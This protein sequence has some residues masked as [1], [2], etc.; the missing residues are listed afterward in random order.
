M[1]IMEEI[2]RSSA[3]WRWHHFRKPTQVI[4]PEVKY[5]ALAREAESMALGFFAGGFHPEPA[6]FGSLRVYV[7]KGSDIVFS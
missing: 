2:R 3:R 5:E 7:Y 1:V 6:F 4:L